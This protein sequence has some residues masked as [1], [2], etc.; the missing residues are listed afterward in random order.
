M[1]LKKNIFFNVLFQILSLLI[2]FITAP[3]VARVIGAEGVGIYSYTSSVAAYFALFVVLGSANYGCKIIARTRDNIIEKSRSFLG[4]MW[5][6]IICLVIVLL[7]YF[8]YIA[9]NT[10]YH[11]AMLIQIIYLLSV[12]CDF[13]WYFT[14]TEQFQIAFKYGVI[15]RTIELILIFILV[16]GT[17]D[18]Y[19]YMLIMTIGTLIS[20]FIMYPILAKQVVWVKV[21]IKEVLMHL[22]PMILLFIPILAVSIF[23]IMDKIMLE[24]INHNISAV[25][26]YEYS[27]KI[28]KLPL[29]VI[30]AVGTVM[31]SKISNLVEKN[32]DDQFKYL[33]SSS[34]NYLGILVVAMAF[35]MAGIA[36]VFSL[37]F[38]GK[39]FAECG[40]IITLLSV[41]VITISWANIIR[42]QYLI[43]RDKEKIYIIAVVLGALINLGLNAIFI[44]NYGAIGAAIGTI[45]AEVTVCLAHTIGVS[46][47]INLWRYGLTWLSYGGCGF[48]MFAVVRIIGKLCFASLTT[49]IIQIISGAAI[50][51]VL[52]SLL[53]LVKGDPLALK[54]WRR[55]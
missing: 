31:L 41:I 39:E 11:V 19:V 49:V 43:P 47:E 46:K 28:V 40:N 37:V 10:K 16:R 38:Y 25:G 1:S 5:L 54:I 21:S 17:K 22:K 45:G 51:V 18:L 24:A 48:V 50:Y 12:G 2:G 13:S 33:F 35:G 6:Q 53:L 55:K 15:I 52:I 9:I 44:P 23:T 32:D 8:G 36:P 7:V 26:I 4:I 29:G 42:T 30:S 14:G 3:Y 27:E 34:M 20:D